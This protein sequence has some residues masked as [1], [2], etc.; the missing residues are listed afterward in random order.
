VDVEEGLTGSVVVL[1]GAPRTRGRI[2]GEQLRAQIQDDLG[3]WADDAAFRT[4]LPADEYV[5][6][7]LA[8]TRFIP[9]IEHH[10]P[11]LL[12][13]LRGI[14]DGA[15]Q[16]FERLLAYN[17][18]DEEWW[19]ADPLEPH[20]ACSVVAFAGDPAVVGQNMDLPRVMDGGQAVLHIVAE[21][22]HEQAVLTAAGMVGLTGASSAAG[23]C[24]NALGMLNRSPHGLPVAFVTRGALECRSQAEAVA[25]VRSVH[26]AS[27]QHYAIVGPDGAIGLECS[28]GGVVDAGE[29]RLWHTNHPLVTSDVDPAYIERPDHIASTHGRF[30]VLTERAPHAV[31]AD[32][33]RRILQEPTAHVCMGRLPGWH[34]FT[35]GSVVAEIGDDVAASFALGPPDTAEW[36]SVRLPAATR[37]PR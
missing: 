16:P 20:D 17:L 27:G 9:A 18:M 12:E 10:T 8:D 22:G 26:H 2:H 4:G 34:W 32:D 6:R 30:R 1:E 28:A 3:R 19:Y 21:D 24:V 13:E 5:A 31:D 25:F 33:V 23:V 37:A 29:G 11:L 36:V 7:F 14:A 15:G 35:F